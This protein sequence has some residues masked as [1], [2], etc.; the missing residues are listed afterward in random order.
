MEQGKCIE[1]FKKRLEM[2]DSAFFDKKIIGSD[3]EIWSFLGKDKD[4]FCFQMHRKICDTGRRFKL[5]DRPDE[6]EKLLMP[7]F[8]KLSV[9]QFSDEEQDEI[10][11]AGII[12]R[13]KD[14]TMII[15]QS[16]IKT[17]AKCLGVGG[18]YIDI[19]SIYR[20]EYL[21]HQLYLNAATSMHLLGRGKRIMAVMKE[22]YKPIPQI[23]LLEVAKIGKFSHYTITEQETCMYLT[24]PEIKERLECEY[25]IYSIE[26][27]VC[28]RIGNLGDTA[29]IAQEIYLMNGGV[30]IGSERVSAKHTKNFSIE[31]FIESIK[32]DIFPRYKR[33]YATFY[34]RSK[35]VL[36]KE[37]ALDIYERVLR[38]PMGTAVF[39]KQFLA[40]IKLSNICTAS[41][42]VEAAIMATKKLEVADYVRPK[43]SAAFLELLK[44][45]DLEA[46]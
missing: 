25:P 42:A 3:I 7:Q 29:L 43:M 8:T 15:D 27:G 31:K 16:A 5:R 12:L 18:D 38:K 26:P 39:D 41:E 17:F 13:Y 22:N 37:Q 44:N 21:S 28:V 24:F 46:V 4:C 36:Y 10:I 9:F 32:N 1:K 2:I 34:S 20:N 35:L 33:F 11:R 30:I 45:I 14:E 6:L 23:N 40:N 19:S